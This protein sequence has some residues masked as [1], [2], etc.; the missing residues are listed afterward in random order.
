[1]S[2]LRF[3]LIGHCVAALAGVGAIAQSGYLAGFLTAWLGGSA[4]SL[5]LA[6]VSFRAAE[7]G[8][9][10]TAVTNDAAAPGRCRL[11]KV[12]DRDLGSPLPA[13]LQADLAK[14][15]LRGSSSYASLIPG[16]VGRRGGIRICSSMS[17]SSRARPSGA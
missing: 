9:F 1:M 8:I 4:L 3:L 17:L 15:S 5:L 7:A 6:Y 13:C 2:A 10:S 12:W 11:V 16:R 14:G